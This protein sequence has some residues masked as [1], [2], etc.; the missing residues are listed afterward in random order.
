MIYYLNY[1]NKYI[2]MV[3]HGK[4]YKWRKIIIK[5]FI[6]KLIFLTKYEK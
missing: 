5:Y 3:D 6:H 1:M 2:F 4:K